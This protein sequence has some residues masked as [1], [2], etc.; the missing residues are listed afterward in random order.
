LTS[1]KRTV[2]ARVS[3]ILRNFPPAFRECLLS[4]H[5]TKPVKDM[6]SRIWCVG[7]IAVAGFALTGSLQAVTP[8]P[9][10]D[11]PGDNTAEGQ[12]ALAT[13]N[14]TIGT[15]N[16]ALGFDALRYN[17]TGYSNTAT[18]ASAL[19]ANTNG[20]LN[21]ATGVLALQFNTSGSYNTAV[22]AF[23]L[24][25]NTAGLHNSAFGLG[26][27]SQNDG[28]D[29]TAIGMTAL[30]NNTAGG[31]NTAAGFSALLSNTTGNYNLADGAQALYANTSGS[32][33]TAL[34]YEVLVRNTTGG[35]NTAAGEAALGNST[36]GGYDS[37][38]GAGA[39]N[40][41][42][43]GSNNTAIGVNALLHNTSGNNNTALGTSAGQ[44]LTT[45]SNNIHIGANVVGKA[46]EANTI[47][48][49]IQGTQK[50]TF[51]AGISGTAVT[52]AQVVVSSTG[53]LGVA[54]S[55]ERFK[56]QIKP[57][58][59]ESEAI[60][61]L[62]PV[63]FRYKDEIDP[64]RTPQFG[65]VAE[66]VEKIDPALVVHD[67]EG[68]PFTVRYEA[69]NAM[70]LNEFLK[71]NQKFERDRREYE[72]RFAAQEKQIAAMTAELKAQRVVIEK[73]SARIQLV[74]QLVAEKP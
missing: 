51:I 73:V 10:G 68:K 31:S 13:D 61:K 24:G 14:T 65:L 36:I 46:G 35:Y 19:A 4:K 53:K 43:T 48:L 23:A 56:E 1:A 50:S 44:N 3:K 64:N 40:L 37:A 60:L 38:Y 12:N 70:L 62:K 52:G 49:G 63:T 30:E 55:S 41:N 6:D 15:E 11:Y 29:N 22:G 74:P 39:L 33:N 9:D 2:F 42:T 69:V 67:E 58:D 5:S 26:A 27:L 7:L 34:G 20:A 16:T 71:Q 57:M 25:R 47:R 8:A 18:G 72:A 32:Y 45:G 54:G 66:E 59:S 17:D 28:N 21:T